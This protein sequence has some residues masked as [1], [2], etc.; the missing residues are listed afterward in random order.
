M[1]LRKFVSLGSTVAA[2]AALGSGPDHRDGARGHVCGVGGG[3]AGRPGSGEVRED[4][5]GEGEAR[6]SGVRFGVG[7]RDCR[8]G[9][10]SVNRLVHF[11]AVN[12]DIFRRDNAE[13]HLIAADLDYHL[14]TI[15]RCFLLQ[16]T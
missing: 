7:L 16:S 14:K 2:L 1:S 15:W 12:G 6:R 10:H 3:V 11:F 13:P 8:L 5:G 9:L 4:R